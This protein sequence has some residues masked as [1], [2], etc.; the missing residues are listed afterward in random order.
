MDGFLVRLPRLVLPQIC[1]ANYLP[2]GDGDIPR[3]GET[4]GDCRPQGKLETNMYFMISNAFH[5]TKRQIHHRFWQIDPSILFLCV[6]PWPF[7]LGLAQRSDVKCAANADDGR[8]T[9]HQ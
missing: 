4:G 5:G 7:T 2:H 9:D 6:P 3:G 8:L 1:P